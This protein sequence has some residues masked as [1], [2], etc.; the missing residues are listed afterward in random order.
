MLSYA[1]LDDAWIPKKKQ[2]KVKKVEYENQDVQN[3]MNK[4]HPSSHKDLIEQALHNFF[5]E[6]K[7][8]NNMFLVAIC[9]LLVIDIVLRLRT[10]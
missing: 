2:S 9:I 5:F 3:I 6:V 7:N 10:R 8:N 1:P 4:I